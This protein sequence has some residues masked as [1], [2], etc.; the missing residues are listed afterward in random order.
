MSRLANPERHVAELE[1]VFLGDRPNDR[2]RA[3]GAT[4]TAESLLRAKA[5]EIL[6]ITF[7]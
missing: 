6:D 7:R 3:L 2:V 1:F 4:G 5:R